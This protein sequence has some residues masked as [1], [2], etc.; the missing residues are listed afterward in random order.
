M[1]FAPA[2]AAWSIVAGP[3]PPSTC[4]KGDAC[5][6]KLIRRLAGPRASMNVTRSR[7]P[8][9]RSRVQWVWPGPWVTFIRACIRMRARASSS[10]ACPVPPHL[11][12]SYLDVECRV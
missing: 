1:L 5:A 9:P 7:D 2:A 12:T 8:Q 6:A 4:G 11:H 3:S 10:L